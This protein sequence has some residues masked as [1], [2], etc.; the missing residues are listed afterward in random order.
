M[1]HLHFL[2]LQSRNVTPWIAI[3]GSESLPDLSDGSLS[4]DIKSGKE[5]TEKVETQELG[6]LAS[7]ATTPQSSL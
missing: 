1:L 3:S 2:L 6:H 4:T 5:G 7:L